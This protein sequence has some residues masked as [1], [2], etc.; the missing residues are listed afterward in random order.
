MDKTRFDRAFEN[1]IRSDEEQITGRTFF[2]TLAEIEQARAER[3]IELQA[4][5]VG[6]QLQFSPSPDVTVHGNEIMLGNQRIV[7]RVS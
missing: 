2:E 7:V 5:I 3:T 6:G 1:F 4:S